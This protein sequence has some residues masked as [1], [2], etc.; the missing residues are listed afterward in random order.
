MAKDPFYYKLD[1]EFRG[2]RVR[3]Q[4]SGHTYEG[5]VRMWHYNQHAVLLYDVTRDDGEHLRAVA[6]DEPETVER[7]TSGGPI[8]IIAVEAIQPSPYSVRDHDTPDHQRFV[9]ETRER[10]H[11]LTFPT[12]RPLPTGEY[13]TVG[14]HKRMEAARRAIAHRHA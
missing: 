1:N 12:V 7:L 9:R 5:W 3:V 4:T 6:I 14:G 11:L 13:E 8:R 10:G 2:T